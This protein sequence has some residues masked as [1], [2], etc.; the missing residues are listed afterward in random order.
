MGTAGLIYAA[1][2]AAWAAYLVP[3]WL[4]RHDEESESRSVDRFST[5]MRVLAARRQSASGGPGGTGDVGE[6]SA[7]TPLAPPDEPLP[8]PRLSPATR[9]RRTLVGLLV[10]T[11]VTLLLAA[12]GFLPWW[13]FGVMAA[14]VVCFLGLSI[15]AGARERARRRASR[16]IADRTYAG[17]AAERTYAEQAYA[18]G[19]EP[20]LEDEGEPSV[21]AVLPDDFGMPPPDDDRWDPVDVPLPTYVTKAVATPPERGKAEFDG[22]ET[23][24]DESEREPTGIQDELYEGELDADGQRR[25]VGD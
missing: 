18:A 2:V 1:I 3:L 24:L 15:R 25:A 11:T 17:H 12:V 16:R 5:A 10:P 20:G 4:R 14:V 21:I 9:R 6:A 8:V 19:G 22:A 13:T 7:E 23:V